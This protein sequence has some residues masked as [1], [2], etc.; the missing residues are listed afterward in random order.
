MKTKPTANLMTNTMRMINMILDE[1]VLP[2][3]MYCPRCKEKMVVFDYNVIKTDSGRER[4]NGKC[5]NCNNKVYKIL[6]A[7]ELQ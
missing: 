6:G 7:N 1:G 3:D 2:L 4:A 5:P